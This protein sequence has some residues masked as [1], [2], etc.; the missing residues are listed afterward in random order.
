MSS[1]Q[2]VLRALAAIIA[3]ALIVGAFYNFNFTLR[4]EPAPL[5]RLD[6]PQANPS[7]AD[8]GL[9]FSAP[10]LDG[11]E[12]DLSHYRGHPVIVDFWATWCGPCRKQIPELVS[13]YKKYNKSRGLVIIGVSCD[14]IQGDGVRAVAPFV[15]KFRINYPI[16]LADQRLVDSMSVEAIPTTLFV[17][18]DGK[19]VSR[20]VGAGRAGEISARAKQL[21]DGVK[22]YGSPAKP[23]ENSGHVVNI[24]VVN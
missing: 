9:D 3:L 11:K 5:L 2:Q 16:A 20:I 14:L 19:L 4:E 15:E 24:S 6:T 7:P 10:G 12:I 22:G 18:P 13:L 21:L 23:G 17:G 1:R 8:E